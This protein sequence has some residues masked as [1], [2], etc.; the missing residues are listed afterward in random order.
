MSYLIGR[1][2]IAPKWRGISAR[3][4]RRETAPPGL[5][6]IGQTALAEPAE[7]LV[8]ILESAILPRLLAAH[9]LMP[10]EREPA[11]TVPAP[12]HLNVEAL[13]P[14]ALD[15]EA[16]ALLDHVDA[17]LRDGMTVDS[18][19][20]D[21]LAPAARYLGE[22]WED[23]RC[24]FIEVTMGLWRLQE[25][26]REIS[27]RLPPDRRPDCGSRHALF[28]AM[29]GEQ[30]S[31]GT[32][33]IDETFRRDGW[34]TEALLDSTRPELIERIA[35]DWFDVVGLTVSRDCNIDPLPHLIRALRSVSRNPRIVVMVGGRVFMGDP[36][37]AA[38]VG[39]DGTAPDAVRAVATA[40]S[41]VHAVSCEAR[42]SG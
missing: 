13:V 36:S 35:R 32:V 16:N 3:I 10:K 23:D 18:L 30:H 24:D 37:L 25:V 2:P 4:W 6:G 41:L 20:V 33:L 40:G 12:D 31:F 38:A 1:E 42:A 19:F 27:A 39:A 29:P 14:M 34:K 8:E 17:L 15:G 11:T 22:L 9:G 28:A 21:L 5:S 26:V 7:P